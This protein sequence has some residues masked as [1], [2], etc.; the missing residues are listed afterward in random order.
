MF[1]WMVYHFTYPRYSTLKTRVI[2]HSTG[3]GWVLHRRYPTTIVSVFL[4]DQSSGRFKH[5]INSK[6]VVFDFE[7][8]FVCLR[9][10]SQWKSMCEDTHLTR[11]RG[12]LA[13]ACISFYLLCSLL[14]LLSFLR[15][16]SLSVTYLSV[17]I[18]F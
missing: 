7:V 4:K 18:M 16:L 15:F 1:E 8:F 3:W 9:C 12:L 5:C 2:I 6:V 10:S 13:A 17:S 11:R 14:I